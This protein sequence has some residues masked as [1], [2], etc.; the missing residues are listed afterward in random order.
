MNKLPIAKFKYE[1]PEDFLRITKHHLKDA[2]KNSIS[3]EVGD[4]YTTVGNN[5]M[6]PI[7]CLPSSD[8]IKDVVNKAAQIAYGM[9]IQ[10]K[11][12]DGY[13]TGSWANKHYKTGQSLEHKHDQV[14]FSIAIYLNVPKD[15]GNFELFHKNEWHTIDVTAGDV[16]VFPG[17]LLHRTQ[18]SRSDSEEPRVVISVNTN[19]SNYILGRNLTRLSETIGM[20]GESFFAAMKTG[21]E[22]MVED[23]IK[24]TEEI[25]KR[26]ISLP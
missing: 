3:L 5:G 6:I 7:H 20:G 10:R 24:S 11:E 21:F 1:I 13:I 19:R 4:A 12:T 22:Q 9:E 25:E 8:W 16:L 14:E 17:S 15:S 26:L 18:E 23:S 2:E